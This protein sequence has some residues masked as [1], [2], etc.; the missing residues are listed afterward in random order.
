M[1]SEH[2]KLFLGINSEYNQ[3]ASYT[4]ANEQNHILKN[5]FQL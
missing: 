1:Y 2:R 5:Y 4:T 3:S